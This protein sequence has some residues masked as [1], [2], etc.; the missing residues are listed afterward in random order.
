MENTELY[1]GTY[2]WLSKNRDNLS[3]DRLADLAY[4]EKNPKKIR[5]W[6]ITVKMIDAMMEFENEDENEDENKDDL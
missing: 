5:Q 3:R 1:P 4:L 6:D 2:A